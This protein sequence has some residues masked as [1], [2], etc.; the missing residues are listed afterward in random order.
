MMSQRLRASPI[1]ALPYQV[2]IVVHS[3]L[4]LVNLRRAPRLLGLWVNETI[5]NLK[6]KYVELQESHKKEI[7][8]ARYEDYFSYIDVLSAVGGKV[9]PGK[10][11]I[12][13]A[14]P[15]K[16][17]DE[18][19]S[20]VRNYR[21][22]E[23]DPFE[24]DHT[25]HEKERTHGE[26]LATRKKLEV[27]QSDD[28]RLDISYKRQSQ[29]KQLI[30]ANLVI[31]QDECGK[32]KDQVN[33][34]L[35]INQNLK[36]KIEEIHGGEESSVLSF[37]MDSNKAQIRELQA[38]K[39][40][41]TNGN[42]T[43]RAAGTTRGTPAIEYFTRRFIKIQEQE[44]IQLGQDKGLLVDDV[45]ELRNATEIRQSKVQLLMREK[46]EAQMQLE[47]FQREMSSNLQEDDPD[48]TLFALLADVPVSNRIIA[49]SVSNTSSAAEQTL[50]AL[51]VERILFQ[52]QNELYLVQPILD[53][54][55]S[56]N[57]RLYAA[58]GKATSQH[59]G[60]W[61]DVPH[62]VRQQLDRKSW[63]Q[64]PIDARFD[65]SVITYNN[66]DGAFTMGLNHPL[67]NLNKWKLD[68]KSY[69]DVP[70]DSEPTAYLEQQ[71]A[72]EECSLTIQTM[73]HG[74]PAALTNGVMVGAT[75]D[76]VQQLH[77][78]VIVPTQDG[79]RVSMYMMIGD[80]EAFHY[81]STT[82]TWRSLARHPLLHEEV[83]LNTSSTPGALGGDEPRI[84]GLHVWKDTDWQ[85]TTVKKPAKW[86]EDQGPPAKLRGAVGLFPT[87]NHAAKALN[88]I[89]KRMTEH[90]FSPEDMDG[91]DTQ[92]LQNTFNNS[93][94]EDWSAFSTKQ[95]DGACQL[96]GL[97]QRI[98]TALMADV[99]PYRNVI[100]KK[101]I[102]HAMYVTG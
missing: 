21:G 87:P 7:N 28:N 51:R 47:R 96:F 9:R 84:R 100:M 66:R 92:I 77:P 18:L 52:F 101:C 42:K 58:T 57:T 39:D 90:Q 19:N 13:V 89:E 78:R 12:N 86:F 1:I 61:P 6:F 49:K 17:R 23:S 35:Q 71:S 29:E 56:L 54:Y 97:K 10:K 11:C 26:L 36:N 33:E 82:Q 43:G 14:T 99:P 53:T 79:N 76:L 30:Q 15:E 44:L 68:C 27:T 81:S 95:P 70:V 73:T 46:Q 38:E 94:Y 64:S 40:W 48:E 83:R 98:F 102:R 88:C 93:N 74:S 3:L 4:E 8:V 2:I 50:A 20:Q 16:E 85:R 31:A 72:R 69:G 60:C 32:F 75:V 91:T 37:Y 65:Y 45:A 55:A 41:A 62:A 24:K 80:V 67:F 5:H 22:G 34:Q 25:T 59:W 63:T